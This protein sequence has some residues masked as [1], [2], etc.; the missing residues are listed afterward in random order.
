MPEKPSKEKST[1]LLHKPSFLRLRQYM[2]RWYMVNS[3]TF[4]W[5]L[6][7]QLL[8]STSSRTSWD[9]TDFRQDY[10][11]QVEEWSRKGENAFIPSML[12]PEHKKVFFSTSTILYLKKRQEN[13][14]RYIFGW[15]NAGEE[16]CDSICLAVF[17]GKNLNVKWSK[18]RVKSQQPSL[19]WP[20]RWSSVSSYRDNS[21][22]LDSLLLLE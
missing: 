21:P 16:K 3:L 10:L 11:L 20:N 2:Q 18:K 7:K 17:K 5:K 15:N 12:F 13:C 1:F 9:R 14:N 4:L 22:F 8:D 19:I 6:R